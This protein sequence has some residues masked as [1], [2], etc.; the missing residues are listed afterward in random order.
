MQ[1]G[2]DNLAVLVRFRL[3]S[4]TYYYRIMYSQSD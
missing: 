2:I 4:Y 1:V 3:E